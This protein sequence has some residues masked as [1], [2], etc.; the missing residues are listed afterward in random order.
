MNVEG[1]AGISIVAV[2]RA[3]AERARRIR[4]ALPEARLVLPRRFAAEDACPYDG[5]AGAVVATVF[6]ESRALVLVMATGIAVR[7]LAPLLGDKR[8]DPAV[9][10]VDDAGRFAISLAGGHLGG[11]NALTERI[12]AAIGAV[13]V[14]TTASEL[15]GLPALDL[16]ARDRGWRIAP[17]SDLTRVMAALVNGDPVAL[18]QGCGRRDWLSSQP[19]AN[20][21]LVEAPAEIAPSDAAAIVISCRRDV[22]LPLD[23]PLALFRPAVL[24]LGAGSSL[25]APPED[26]LA[27]AEAALAECDRASEAVACVATI[28]RR[29]AEPA[30]VALA[31]RFGVDVRCFTPAELEAAPG[32]W[33]RSE[34]VRRAVAAGGVAEPA[35]ILASAGGRLLLGKRRSAHATVAVAHCAEDV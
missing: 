20:L 2:S 21:R 17:G 35:A 16:V 6:A 14:I 31:A 30:I 22:A 19:S 15:A 5:G 26:L 11:A 28:E 1:G 33:E 27:L 7:L 8:S 9:V 34:V 29:R 10:V 25:G 4:A 3:G 18:F 13:P 12:A 32:D 24:V 23:V